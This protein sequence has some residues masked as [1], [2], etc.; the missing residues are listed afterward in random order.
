MAVLKDVGH[1]PY[2]LTSRLFQ[3]LR[4]DVN[5]A[6]AEVTGVKV[7]RGASTAYMALQYT[8]RKDERTG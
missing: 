8:Y 3:F 6:F 7:N 2:N 4:R 5:K 1:V